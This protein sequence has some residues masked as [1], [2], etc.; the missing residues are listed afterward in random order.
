M[1]NKL[2]LEEWTIND[3]Y[4]DEDRFG[5]PIKCASIGGDGIGTQI[6]LYENDLKLLQTILEC[7]EEKLKGKNI[8]AVN[9]EHVIRAIGYQ[10]MYIPLYCRNGNSKI[11]SESELCRLLNSYNIIRF[12]KKGEQIASYTTSYKVL[13]EINKRNL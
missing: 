8:V 10:G 12:N 7:N 2:H 5:K 9:K 11:L 1:N 4:D 6:P 13:E 3:I